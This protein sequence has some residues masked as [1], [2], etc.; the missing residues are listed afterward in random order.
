M[1]AVYRT[2]Y[3]KYEQNDVL[4]VG[5]QEVVEAEKEIDTFL[6]SLDRNQRDQLDTLLGRLSRAYEMQ[7]FL[8]GG[9]ASGAKWNGKT[10]PEPG[11]G[12][13][14]S[15]RA[16]HGSTLAPVCQIDRKTN[17]VI[18]EYPSIAAASRATGLDDS[19]IGKVRIAH[20]YLLPP[21]NSCSWVRDAVVLPITV[22]LL[23]C[24]G[25]RAFMI[26]PNRDNGN[27]FRASDCKIAE[28]NIFST[29]LFF[30]LQHFLHLLFSELLSV[31]ELQGLSLVRYLVEYLEVL[32]HARLFFRVDDAVGRDVDDSVLDLR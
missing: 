25:G 6:K 16:Y 10:A 23:S 24:V 9:L 8:F 5:I 2:L 1:A 21:P 7:G 12:Y 3:E 14:R 22:V 27:G 17:Q 31:N 13:G 15:V 29:L 19:A 11:D 26:A 20:R 32:L 18:H 4:H 30:S 28:Y